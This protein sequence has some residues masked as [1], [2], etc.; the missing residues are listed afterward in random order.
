MGCD[1][2]CMTLYNL[3]FQ[4]SNCTLTI[5]NGKNLWYVKYVPININSYV[6]NEQQI[7]LNKQYISSQSN[8]FRYFRYFD[9]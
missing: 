9:N 2:G 4:I 1:D 6:Y 8:T 5:Y 3:T 7:L